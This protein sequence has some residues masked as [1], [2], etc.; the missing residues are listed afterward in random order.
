MA[1][2]YTGNVNKTEKPELIMYYTSYRKTDVENLRIGEVRKS[3]N[4][5]L[6]WEKTRDMK[7]AL[8]FGL[9]IIELMVWLRRIIV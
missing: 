4:P 2:G 5:H 1:I 9:L 3:S 7:V 8:D 6:R